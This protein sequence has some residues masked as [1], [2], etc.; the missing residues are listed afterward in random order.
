MRTIQTGRRCGLQGHRCGSRLSA[1]PTV[2][3]PCLRPRSTEAPWQIWLADYVTLRTRDIT[4]SDLV[5]RLG[6]VEIRTSG[7]H[8]RQ[9]QGTPG[10]TV[11][12]AG[13][14]DGRPGTLFGWAMPEQTD[15]LHAQGIEHVASAPPA[16]P[17]SDSLWSCLP[18]LERRS[19]ISLACGRLTGREGCLGSNCSPINISDEEP[20]EMTKDEKVTGSPGA[21][22]WD[23]LASGGEPDAAGFCP[24]AGVEALHCFHFPDGLE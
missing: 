11:V 7:T 3:S 17:R 5:E 14:E 24:D 2:C 19:M 13:Q 22:A 4:Y 6:S 12:G 10:S 18:R 9:P 16:R 1:K 15:I 21:S 23:A 20:S 8:M